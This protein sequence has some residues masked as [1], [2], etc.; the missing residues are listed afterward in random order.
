MTKPKQVTVLFSNGETRRM[1]QANRDRLVGLD[2]EGYVIVQDDG[3]TFMLTACC[4]ATAKGSE[5]GTVCRACYN[6]V[7]SYLGC[8]PDAVAA[9]PV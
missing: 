6:D 8:Q 1:T 7:D 4:N 5:W 9:T 2:P 3:M